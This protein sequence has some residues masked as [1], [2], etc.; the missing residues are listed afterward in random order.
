VTLPEEV[1]PAEELALS[2]E[3]LVCEVASAIIAAY[4]L[5]VPCALQYVQQE[6]V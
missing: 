1:I 4:T 5:G 6:L 3:A 2:T